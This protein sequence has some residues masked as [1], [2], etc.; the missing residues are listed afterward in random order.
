MPAI[1]LRRKATSQVNLFCAGF[2]GVLEVPG[3]LNRRM[4]RSCPIARGFYLLIAWQSRYIIA[5]AR[6]AAR[7]AGAVRETWCPVHGSPKPNLMP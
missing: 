5:P 1:G 6:L 2:E 3:A 4:G 7:G